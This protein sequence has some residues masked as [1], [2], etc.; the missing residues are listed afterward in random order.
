MGCM[1]WTAPDVARVDPPYVADELTSLQSWLEFHRR[2][3]LW[4]CSG[5]TG[6]QLAAQAVG[7]SSLSLLGL[8]RHMAKVERWW[9]RQHFAGRA[10]LEHLY[11]TAQYPDGDFDLADGARAEHDFAVFAAECAAADDAAHGRSLDETFRYQRVR[12]QH[13]VADIDLRW[14][15]QHMIEE[16]ARHNGHADLLRERIDGA[17]GQ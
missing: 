9:F 7:P 10:D 12:R 2:T 5:L 11:C 15:Y 1:T 8:I 17:T 13:E 14:V 6:E 3:L 16:Y 4:K